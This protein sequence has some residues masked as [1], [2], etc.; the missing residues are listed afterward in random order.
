MVIFHEWNLCYFSFVDPH[1]F[2]AM[3]LEEK[4]CKVL[5]LKFEFDFPE[6]QLLRFQRILL[7]L[8]TVD[9]F[10]YAIPESSPPFF[11]KKENKLLRYLEK[12]METH[13][14]DYNKL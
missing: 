5:K 4:F 11:P 14:L 7:P 10:C 2:E 3:G 1:G 6:V 13:Q 12:K 8:F 9:I